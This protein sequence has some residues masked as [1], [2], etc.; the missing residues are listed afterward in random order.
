M[1]C[2]NTGQEQRWPATD[3]AP[4]VSD[5]LYAEVV[6]RLHAM[7]LRWM[8]R[9]PRDAAI[10]T[11]SFLRDVWLS[12]LGRGEVDLDGCRDLYRSYGRAMQDLILNQARRAIDADET[13]VERHDQ[14][15]ASHELLRIGE[16]LEQ[17][18]TTDPGCVDVVRLRYFGGLHEV[19]VAACLGMTREKTRLEWQYARSCIRRMLT[20]EGTR[21]EKG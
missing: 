8:R 1:M 17:L 13:Q 10:D 14:A 19:E 21:T 11:G 4:A 12:L 3:D 6:P 18:A 2:Q 16:A 15:N 7:T 20:D 9:M 5:V